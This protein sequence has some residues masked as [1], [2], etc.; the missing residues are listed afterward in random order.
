[1]TCL[2]H[3]K[4]ALHMRAHRTE[5]LEPYVAPGKMLRN[6]AWERCRVLEVI[7]KGSATS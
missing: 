2:K 1:M 3:S 6:A 7:D 4:H 5:S